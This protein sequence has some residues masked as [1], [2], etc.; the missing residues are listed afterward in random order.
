MPRTRATRKRHAAENTWVPDETEDGSLPT[1]YE[2]KQREGNEL[3]QQAIDDREAA[4][5]ERGILPTAGQWED[6]RQLGDKQDRK[7]QLGFTTA[8]EAF[9]FNKV[10]LV[11]ALET[12]RHE[13]QL[14]NKE[15][16]DIAEAIRQSLGPLNDASRSPE[17][18]E[19]E[20]NTGSGS[21]QS[22]TG[23]KSS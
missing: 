9:E 8:A 13:A 4:A 15:A 5:R 2:E 19:A 20:R 1:E 14:A 3:L 18:G 17:L 10:K 12:Q 21:S 23:T 6:L 11:N 22:A 16:A 7:S